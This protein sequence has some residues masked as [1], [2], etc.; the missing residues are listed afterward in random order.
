MIATTQVQS[1]TPDRA[2][3]NSVDEIHARI[4]SRQVTWAGPLLVVSA[5]T[6]LLLLFQALAAALL[7]FR[8][9][10]YPWVS[11]G[12]WWTVYGTLVDLGC[13]LLMWRFMRRE[14]IGFRDL[15]GR[16]RWRWGRDIFVGLGWFAMTFPILGIC[17]PLSARLIYGTWFPYFDH[18]AVVASLPRWAALY[19]LFVWWVIWSPTEEI[20]YQAYALPRLQALTNRPFLAVL[21]VAFWWAL[22]HCAVPLVLDWRYPIWRVLATFPGVLTFLLVY[23]R[24][25][26]LPPLILAHWPGDIF[27][28]I[29]SVAPAVF[30]H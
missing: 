10:P 2:S 5:R 14:G 8:H 21:F 13:I 27:V 6:V 28:A 12:K 11:A 15:V 4:P 25:R 3:A 30:G 16:V 26:R 9:V 24:T 22:Q 19:T 18:G 23:H 17:L 1:T 20:T 7:A 29:M